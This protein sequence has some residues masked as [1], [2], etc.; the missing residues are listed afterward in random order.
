M[1]AE[2]LLCAQE[3][4]HPITAAL[5]MSHMP[6]RVKLGALD[7]LKDLSSLFQHRHPRLREVFFDFF[8]RRS[9]LCKGREAGKGPAHLQKGEGEARLDVPV[10]EAGQGPEGPGLGL[11]V[12]KEFGSSAALRRGTRASSG[13][14]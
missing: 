8:C 13:Y 5:V 10:G 14:P 1:L 7:Y 12:C 9:S 3:D 2:C 4:G 11:R 6:V